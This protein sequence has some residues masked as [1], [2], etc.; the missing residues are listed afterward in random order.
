MVRGSALSEAAVA[1]CRGLGADNTSDLV[2][3]DRHGRSIEPIHAFAS[4]ILGNA[5]DRVSCSFES[6]PKMSQNLAV[7]RRACLGSSA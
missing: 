1:N 6:F 7:L 5:C 4:K 2:R 3:H